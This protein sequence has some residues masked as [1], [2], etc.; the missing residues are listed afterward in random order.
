MARPGKLIFEQVEDLLFLLVLT[1]G[2][3]FR[4]C[5]LGSYTIT[6]DEMAAITQSSAGNLQQLYHTVAGGVHPFGYYFIL[7][8]WIQWV[9]SSPAMLRLPFAIAGAG[10]VVM[11]YLIGTRWFG[12]FAALLAATCF[13]V[14]TFAV[15]YSQLA[16]PYSLG[17]FFSLVATYCWTFIVFPQRKRPATFMAYVLFVLAGWAAMMMHYFGMMAVATLGLTGLFFIRGRRL[18]YYVVC[19]AIM[20][21]L[22]VPFTTIFISQLERSGLDWLAKPDAGFLQ[23]LLLAFFNGD[24]LFWYVFVVCMAVL[25]WEGRKRLRFGP[26]HFISLVLFVVPLAIAYIKSVMGKPVLQDRS[27]LFHLPY[28]ILFLCAFQAPNNRDFR[29]WYFRLSVWGVL[30]LVGIYSF[31]F[32]AGYFVSGYK[33]FGD[34]KT[35]STDLIEHYQQ[36][37]PKT[38]TWAAS[39]NR[40]PYTQYYAQQQGINIPFSITRCDDDVLLDS[41]ANVVNKAATPYFYFFWCHVGL[42]PSTKQIIQQQYPIVVDDEQGNKQGTSFFA[43]DISWGDTLYHYP[44]ATVDS[45][46]QP[47]SNIAVAPKVLRLTSGQKYSEGVK[48]LISNNGAEKVRVVAKMRFKME[49]QGAEMPKIVLDANGPRGMWKGISL[50]NYNTCENGWNTAYLL[51]D[52]NWANKP[53]VKVYLF[54]PGGATV[55]YQQPEVIVYGIK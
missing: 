32:R 11:I 23:N 6:N 19:G 40:P 51:G 54:N 35:V 36:F 14:S 50:A 37:D 42:M 33:D 4:L 22:Y 38:V 48:L 43:K 21:A 20:L 25:A 1:I 18:I 29:Q 55:Q 27:M 39:V 10:S 2:V 53:D 45:L 15:L 9:G 41:L 13:A 46:A 34:F 24:Y 8:Y 28:L 7:H 17:L 31:V 3:L 16:R 12:R 52:L 44:L 26:F 5:F 47:D 49:R 30:F